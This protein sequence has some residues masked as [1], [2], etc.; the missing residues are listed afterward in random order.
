MKFKFAA[1]VLALLTSLSTGGSEASTYNLVL[2]NSVD[3]AIGSGSFSVKGTIS[4]TGIS[5][6][7]ANSGL[8]SL[9]F[10]I[11]GNNFALANALSIASVTFD[12]GALINIAYL[13]SLNGFSLDLGTL[14]LG[15]AFADLINPNLSS[16]GTIS[17]SATPLPPSWTLMLIGLAGAGF[18][19]YRRKSKPALMAV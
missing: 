17:A 3:A 2:D 9:D 10:S 14:G 6:F 18:V 8:T 15:Y 5:V 13:G 7:K 12:N 16:T 4:S 19:A 11:D 1:L